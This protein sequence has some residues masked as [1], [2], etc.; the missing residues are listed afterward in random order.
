MENQKY[1]SKTKSP[2]VILNSAT[3]FSL[4]VTTMSTIA[5]PR[6]ARGCRHLIFTPGCGSPS[7]VNVFIENVKGGL[8][9]VIVFGFSISA[10]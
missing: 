6:S 1:R 4:E 9:S 5:T 10:A 8:I 2:C 3:P 7:G